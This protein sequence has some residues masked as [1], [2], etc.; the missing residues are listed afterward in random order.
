MIHL[1]KS[2]LTREPH[3]AHIHF[4]RDD[5]GNHVWCDESAC[6][7]TRRPSPMPFPH[8]R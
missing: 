5:H 6:R 8:A 7:P 1:L 4:H 2:L 3:S